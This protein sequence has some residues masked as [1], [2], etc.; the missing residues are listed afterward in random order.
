MSKFIKVTTMLQ[1][2]K[3]AAPK[4]SYFNADNII[5]FREADDDEIKLF[6]TNVSEID[7]K[8]GSGIRTYTVK[9]SV[10]EILAMINE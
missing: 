10:D 3:C 6:K 1:V 7:V 4:P 2:K 9:E 5:R 8:T